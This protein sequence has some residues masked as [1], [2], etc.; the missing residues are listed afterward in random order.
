VSRTGLLDH[1][2][3]AYAGFETF[4]PQLIQSGFFPEGIR[5]GGEVLPVQVRQVFL[6]PPRTEEAACYTRLR[7]FLRRIEAD[8]T[9]GDRDCPGILLG[10]VPALTRGGTLLF[11]REP[12]LERVAILQL[13]PLP[14]VR[15]AR[16]VERL[17]RPGRGE[18]DWGRARSLLARHNSAHGSRWE[19]TTIASVSTSASLENY[20]VRTLQDVLISSVRSALAQMT[21]YWGAHPLET[22]ADIIDLLVPCL[23]RMFTSLAEA[24][25]ARSGLLQPLDTLNPLAELAHKRKV[26]FCG[27][28]GVRSLHGSKTPERP[29]DDSHQGR[30]CPV[31]TPESAHIGLNLHLALGAALREGQV[32]ESPEADA[33]LL[34]LSASLIPFVEHNDMNRAMMGAK[35][36]KQALPL[37]RPE[38]PL[39]RTGLE[40]RVVQEGALRTDRAVVDGGLALGVNLRVAYL[41]WYG[42]NFEDAIV[43]SERAAARLTSLHP[44]RRPSGEGAEVREGTEAGEGMEERPLQVGDKLTGRHGNKGVVSR[45]LPEAEMPRLSADGQPVDVLLNP[46]GVISRMNIGQ[47]LETHWGWVAHCQ[48]RPRLAPPFAPAGGGKELAAALAASG[49]P[50]GKAELTWTGPDGR[51]KTAR[52]VAGYQYLMKLNH[53]AADKLQVRATGVRTALTQQPPRSRK[54]GRSP[55]VIGGQRVGEMEVWALQSH[56]AKS[57]LAEMLGIKAEAGAAD[58]PAR[59]PETLCVLLCYLRAMG[60]ETT[61][62]AGPEGQR[63]EIDWARPD[64]QLD[65]GIPFQARFAFADEGRIR[66]WADGRALTEVSVWEN[67][68]VCRGCGRRAGKG[69]RG[70]PDGCRTGLC[71]ELAW[72][73]DGL[74]GRTLFGP[75]EDRERR[76]G[77]YIT[78]ESEVPHPL[79]PEVPL[80]EL[81]V[82]PPALRPLSRRDAGLNVWYRK[83]LLANRRLTKGDGEDGTRLSRALCQAV[84]GLF[85]K[86]ARFG[87]DGSV[88]YGPAPETARASSL[89]ARLEGK[90]GLLRGFLLGKRV[91]FSGRAVIVPDP[92]LP[93]GCCRLPQAAGGT[94]AGPPGRTGGAA[95]WDAGEASLPLVLL[96]R[97]PSLHRYNLL[98]FGLDPVRPFGEGSVLALH[99]LACG[100]FGADFDGDTMAFHRPLSREAQEEARTRLSAARNLFSV[101]HGG[102]LLHLAQDIVAG[103]YLMTAAGAEEGRRWLGDL[104]G[105]GALPP[106]SGPVTG[107]ALQAAV[108]RH[109]REAQAAGGEA[110][111]DALSGVDVLMRRAFQEAT[112]RGLSFAISD[113]EALRLSPDAVAEAARQ[114]PNARTLR[115]GL[116]ALLEGRLRQQ[117][118]NHPVAAL[119]LSGARGDVKQLARLCGAVTRLPDGGATASYLDGLTPPQYFEAAKEARQDMMPKKLGT[120]VGGDLTRKLVYG[121]YPLRIVAGECPAETGLRLPASLLPHLLGKRLA[122]T[123]P[124]LAEKDTLLDARMLER[125]RGY[126]VPVDLYSPV[127]CQAEGG[128]CAR[129]Y[130]WDLSTEQAPEPGLPVGILAAQSIG[131]RATQDFMKVFQGMGGGVS[132]FDSAKAFLEWGTLPAQGWGAPPEEGGDGVSGGPSHGDLLSWLTLT[133]YEGKVN[134]RHL[135]TALRSVRVGA[136][137]QGMVGAARAQFP[138]SPL[139]AAAFQSPVR[140]LVRAALEQTHDDLMLGAAPI[141]VGRMQ[142]GT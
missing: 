64:A 38:A 84:A 46:H 39:V 7:P 95:G 82:L 142:G 21:G 48:G 43:V 73:P 67:V 37:S 97:A 96:N 93:F 44:K 10:S 26:T 103:V 70:C 14:E 91:D 87:R 78:L 71:P 135:E 136:G 104:L 113:L 118:A 3:D 16:A 102:L 27:S 76:R 92:G 42:Y 141:L 117:P 55:A 30:L 111:A 18:T 5:A 125:L 138:D 74:M 131:E 29:V 132:L 15:L 56:L 86:T 108:Q 106:G 54:G 88:R 28:G 11:G 100:G 120:P 81:Y 90:G 4:L 107:P 122:G 58:V 41:P 34:G 53:C 121:L 75:E 2:R 114:S 40:A 24:H 68:R 72:H 9:V 65:P 112:E 137:R 85:G 1:L 140:F 52:V 25:L 134:L 123:V 6:L 45:I 79:A 124:G 36:M 62:W 127:T 98:A 17:T 130:G 60:I 61:L 110:L 13:K 31:E 94:F 101:A 105:D 115:E 57:N 12:V 139:S 77:A 128:I 19:M 119:L 89:P 116:G 59:L 49:M 20:R 8:L 69:E 99:P 109:L 33:G 63:A 32:V 23:P 47:L 35:S 126:A 22:R 51:P 50:D 133:V 83:I 66:D 129:C 80:R